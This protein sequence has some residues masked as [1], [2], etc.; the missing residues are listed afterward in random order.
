MVAMRLELRPLLLRLGLER[1]GSWYLG[2]L[3]QIR[4]VAAV[5]GVGGDRDPV[6]R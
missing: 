3:G 1:R 5:S 4:L 6:G 2:Q